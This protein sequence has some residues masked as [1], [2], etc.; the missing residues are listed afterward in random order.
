M[1]EEERNKLE[2]NKKKYTVIKEI[3]RNVNL[4]NTEL[5]RKQYET[6]LLKLVHK[7]FRKYRSG[8]RAQQGNTNLHNTGWQKETR[9][10]RGKDGHDKKSE[11]NK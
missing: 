2:K 7:P 9:S 6:S 11:G 8:T 4:Q 3:K 5:L 1:S 10:K